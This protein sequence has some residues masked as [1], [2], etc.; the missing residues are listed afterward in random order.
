MWTDE[1]L[2]KLKNTGDELADETIKKIFDTHEI[3]EANK[4]IVEMIRQ[5]EIDL[6]SG[7][8]LDVADTL[9]YYF[10]ESGKPPAWADMDRIKNAEKLFQKHGMIAFSLLGCA[11]LPELYTCGKGGTQ[12]LGMTLELEDHIARRIYETAQ[13][14]IAVMHKGGL[15]NDRGTR[16]AGEGIRRTQKVR[17]MHAAVRFMIL[18]D[19]DDEERQKPPRH[20]GDV[21]L[22]YKWNDQ[23]SMGN[24]KTNWGVPIGQEYL[25]ATLQTFSYV[26]IRGLRDFGIEISEKEANDFI[27]AWNVIG[28]YMGVDP[29]FLRNVNNME[30]A[31]LLY[32][33]VMTRNRSTTPFEKAEG[34][35]LTNALMNFL[36]KMMRDNAPFGKLLPTKLIPRLLTEELVGHDTVKLLGIK[37]SFFQHLQLIPFKVQMWVMGLFSNMS[38]GHQLAHWK[39]RILAKA[40]NDMPRGPHRP[41]FMIPET[42]MGDWK[43]KTNQ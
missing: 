29:I 31:K 27:H 20:F 42:L 43:L 36:A 14:L 10:E 19:V 11:S 39:F 1:L 3:E 16:S 28:H 18:K 13:W 2:E 9:Q 41:P 21:L 37:L 6:G 5:E 15:D 35:A 38:S 40:L 25:G 34:V 26:I 22:K 33:A 23:P 32:D 8:A 30:E 24:N 7:F 4:F 17:L 12:V